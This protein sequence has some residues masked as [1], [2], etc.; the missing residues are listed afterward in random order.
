LVA[1]RARVG[2]NGFAIH[3]E[4]KIHIA[5]QSRHG[6]GRDLDIELP[7]Q[8]SDSGGGLVGPPNAGDGIAGGVVFQQD[9]DGIDYFG[10]FFSTGLRPAPDCRVRP[11][12]TS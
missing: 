3:T 5:K 8:F 1:V 2:G 12:S 10:R 11:T 6:I 9:F 4:G 7:Q